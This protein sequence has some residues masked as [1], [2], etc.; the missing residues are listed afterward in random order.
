MAYSTHAYATWKPWFSTRDQ[1][2]SFSMHNH[3]YAID[4]T[5][6]FTEILAHAH[7][8][9]TRPLFPSPWPGCKASILV[10]IFHTVQRLDHPHEVKFKWNCVMHLLSIHE[11][12]MYMSFLRTSLKLS[13]CINHYRVIIYKQRT[14]QLLC[15][16]K[17]IVGGFS[18]M[19]HRYIHVYITCKHTS[20]LP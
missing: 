16:P 8:I 2:L 1:I 4:V 10:A 7:T 12:C 15:A 6:N 18:Q 3:M 13:G 9:D 14:I 11:W 5:D 20:C 19:I 17:R